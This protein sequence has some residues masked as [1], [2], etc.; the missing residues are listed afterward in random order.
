[1]TRFRV[2]LSLIALSTCGDVARAQGHHGH[3]GGGF[4]SGHV[5]IVVMPGVYGRRYSSSA[6]SGWYSGGGYFPVTSFFSFAPLT[7]AMAVPLP[8]MN[9]GPL[10][11]PRPPLRLMDLN[12]NRP[13][14]QP[15]K[16]N[17]DR[18]KQLTII[19][20]RLFRVGNTKRA[21]DRYAQA[22]RARPQVRRSTRPSGADRVAPRPLLRGGR[23]DPR[24]RPRSRGG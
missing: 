7:V 13:P 2:V 9:Q 18:A 11:G 20:D 1:M 5:P 17:L 8:M 19:G 15:L 24:R 4:G 16:A 6:F 14:A 22:A 23:R 12:G 21:S 3:H 10:A